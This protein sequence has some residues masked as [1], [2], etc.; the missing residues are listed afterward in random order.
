MF[1]F[2]GAYEKKTS[3]FDIILRA[4]FQFS[5]VSRGHIIFNAVDGPD[6]GMFVKGI[7][8][9]GIFAIAFVLRFSNFIFPRLKF[10]KAQALIPLVDPTP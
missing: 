10:L 6:F 4:K 8:L 3:G 5:S 2:G 7:V 9:L 1:H